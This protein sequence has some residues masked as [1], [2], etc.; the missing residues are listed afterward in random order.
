[1]FIGFTPWIARALQKLIPG[2][3][4]DSDRHDDSDSGNSGT[5]WKRIKE[6]PQIFGL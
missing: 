3:E 4:S 6:E 2:R 1:M 5:N